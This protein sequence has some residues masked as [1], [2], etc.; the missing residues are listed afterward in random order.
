MQ[1]KL[2]QLMCFEVGSNYCSVYTISSIG[3]TGHLTQADS[4]THDMF[5]LN[6]APQ[7]ISLTE[8]VTQLRTLAIQVP[9]YSQ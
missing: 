4:Q 5:K 3:P 2:D 9:L 8:H 6:L 7:G 1:S